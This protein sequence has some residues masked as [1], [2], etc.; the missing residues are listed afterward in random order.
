MQ[1]IA[2]IALL[3]TTG[4]MQVAHG[5]NAVREGG[6]DAAIVVLFALGQVASIQCPKGTYMTSVGVCQPDFDFD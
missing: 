3:A 1:K 5:S 2:L 4:M 6:I